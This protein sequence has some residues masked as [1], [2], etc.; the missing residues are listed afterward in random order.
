MPLLTQPWRLPVP[1]LVLP[2]LAV[3]GLALFRL[4]LPWLA[5]A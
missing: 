5:L 1:G 3:A 2:L 4:A